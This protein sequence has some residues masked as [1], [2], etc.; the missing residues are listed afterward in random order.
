MKTLLFH[1]QQSRDPG[2]GEDP[3]YHSAAQS[4]AEKETD[5]EKEK[6]REEGP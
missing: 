5:R 4:G 1:K 6:E 2:L 3:V